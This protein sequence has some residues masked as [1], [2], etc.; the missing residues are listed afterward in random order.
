[1]DLE[2]EDQKPIPDPIDFLEMMEEPIDTKLIGDSAE[3]FRTPENGKG[4]VQIVPESV[5]FKLEHGSG[6]ANDIKSGT[7]ED[8]AP[9]AV[10]EDDLDKKPPSDYIEEEGVELDMLVDEEMG[11][12]K[13]SGQ[14]D[15]LFV[16]KLD[17]EYEEFE[18]EANE[19][20]D[21]NED[22][23]HQKAKKNGKSGE[24]SKDAMIRKLKAKNM[25]LQRSNKEKQKKIHS[26]MSTK[27]YLQKAN[28]AKKTPKETAV[29]SW[30]RDYIIERR[31]PA[32]ANF[33]MDGNSEGPIKKRVTKVFQEQE[34]LKSIGLRRISKKAYNYMRDNGLCPLP[35]KTTLDAWV[36]KNPQ[37]GIPTIGEYVRPTVSKKREPRKRAPTDK[38]D[39]ANPGNDVNPCGR[40][41]KN[42]IKRAQLNEHLAEVHEDERARKLQC[43]VC[44]KWL[45]SEDY[46]VGHRNMH[47]DIKPF[48]CTFCERSYRNPGNMHAHRKEAHAEE[49]EAEK[50]K[51]GAHAG[52]KNSNRCPKCEMAFPFISE[53]FQHLAEIHQ[54]LDSR[55]LQCTT[56]DKWLGSK[57]K[58]Q[59]HMRTHTG[60]RPYNCDFCP[61]TFFSENSMYSHRRDSHR[62]EWEANKDQ[63]KARSKV[64][65]RRKI[66]AAWAKRKGNS[67]EA[68]ILDEA[69]GM[70]NHNLFKCD[71]CEKAYTTKK[72]MLTHQKEAHGDELREKQMKRKRNIDEW[73]SAN[74]CAQCGMNFPLQSALNEHLAQVHE[75]PSA[76]ELQCTDCKKWFGTKVMLTDHKRSHT[77]ERPFKCDFCP[78][79]FT[80]NKTMGAHRK[81]IHHDE[82]EANKDQIMARR[83][84]LATAKR[85]KGSGDVAILDEATGMIHN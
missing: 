16:G 26:L 85:R 54:D 51:R 40:C 72:V 56:C 58:L 10:L 57:Q 35:G 71:F 70:I 83:I 69:T 21:I 82:W 30:V 65:G 38:G 33:I 13:D 32:W 29:K 37:W 18:E 80:T 62:A 64:E 5:L 14:E 81:E 50:S 46:M 66:S 39:D 24:D 59:N 41:G 63:I 53:L 67:G 4:L 77:G 25:A 76:M 19:A 6:D 44:D 7:G 8:P 48:K 49:W 17:G 73:T 74:P 42:F 52:R 23:W 2:L 22:I 84:A 75:D 12:E 15:H 20:F 1:M 68:T 47:M 55:E 11:N 45:G 60:E 31:S 27:S 9:G 78:K 43:K 61:K 34:V 3:T 36:Q 28:Q 79:T